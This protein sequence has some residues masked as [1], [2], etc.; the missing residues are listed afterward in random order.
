MPVT[1]NLLYALSSIM[2][3]I[4]GCPC[5]V[6]GCGAEGLGLTDLGFSLSMAIVALLALT[7][8]RQFRRME[9]Q[10]ADVI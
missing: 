1:R 4:E 9:K 6:V 5:V 7:G 3:I 8:V 10:F 2:S